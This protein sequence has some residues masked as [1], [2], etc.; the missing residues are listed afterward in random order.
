MAHPPERPEYDNDTDMLTGQVV[1]ILDNDDHSFMMERLRDKLDGMTKILPAIPDETTEDRLLRQDSLITLAV[2]NIHEDKHRGL[3][4]LIANESPDINF[5]FHAVT[6]E[7]ER[8]NRAQSA[9]KWAALA[10]KTTETKA[11]P[12]VF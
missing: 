12:R 7:L 3:E 8:M 10:K 1:A 11:N 2:N 4:H 6:D 9:S 5:M